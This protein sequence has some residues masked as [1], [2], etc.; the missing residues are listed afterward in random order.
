MSA[1][2][3]I[4]ANAAISQARATTPQ[5]RPLARPTTAP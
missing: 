4:Y 1:L 5:A 2:T 3:V